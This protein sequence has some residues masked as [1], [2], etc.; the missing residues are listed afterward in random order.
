MDEIRSYQPDRP[1]KVQKEDRFNRWPFAER[2]ADTIG[3]SSDPSGLV[4]GIYGEWGDGKSS[5]LNLMSEALKKYDNVVLVKFN[6]WYFRSEAKL[7]EGFFSILAE[8]L[9]KSLPSK[10]EE[11]GRVLQK[12]GSILS[13]ASGSFLGGMVSVN[14][15]EAIAKIG[16]KMAETDLEELRERVGAILKESNKR[17][18][19]LI[20]DIDR[21]DKEE[22]QAIFKLVKL[23]ASFE[24][25][26]YV[27]AFDD[28]MVAESLSEKYG[29]LNAGRNFLEKIIQVPLRLPAA[30][31]LSLRNL[32]FEGVDSALTSSKVTLTDEQ[33]QI[34][35]NEF[36]PG[37]E[38]RVRTPR[39][40]KRY[41]NVL[42]FA[43]PLLK[44]E[45]NPVDQMLIEGLRVFYPSLYSAIR[46][47]PDVF[48]GNTRIVSEEKLKKRTDETISESLNN[49]GLT[50]GEKEAVT[51]LLEKLFPEISSRAMH[52]SDWKELWVREQRVC[53]ERYF[54]RYFSYG[55]PP[56]DVSDQSIASF[57]VE[58]A[59][60]NIEKIGNDFKGLSKNNKG[61]AHLIEKLRYLE[62]SIQPPIAEKLAVAIAQNGNI[63]PE[64]S[65][66]F[67]FLGSFS[68]GAIFVSMLISRI[69]MTSRG[70][71]AKE[72]IDK[73]N[74]LS[75]AVECFRWLRHGADRPE[76]E[77]KLPIETEKS[78]GEFLAD[79]IKGVAST[80]ALY[81]S[82]PNYA[83]QML[84]I[85]N[86]F[87]AKS[88][89][90]SYL[91]L[92]FSANSEEVSKFLVVLTPTAYGGGKALPFKSD[93][94]RDG[95]NAV[96]NFIDPSV[97]LEYLSKLYGDKLNASKY[98]FGDDIT[99]ENRVAN[100]FAFVHAQVQSETTTAAADVEINKPTL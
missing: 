99:V 38:P 90:E 29:G 66:T 43:L 49:M 56:D 25:V 58:A 76:A 52:G 26:T 4:I 11:L 24:N 33:T 32:T 47:N 41:A 44:G 48:L 68:Q 13:L 51:R 89:V 2:I 20:D 80:E 1:I 50:S 67:S 72:V 5:T 70:N 7:L 57:L 93:F 59:E 63:L 10:A 18:V 45:V 77:R 92:R 30:D 96:R 22:V 75:F 86:E 23:S 64:E 98:H 54:Q 46:E 36:V 84:W 79:K 74:P 97:I 65:T 62:N 87:G 21:L 31:S 27:L 19:V 8:N 55:V 100:Q 91:K 73:A 28:G 88:E 12:I 60:S 16:E 15:G 61:I 69:E 42:A 39:Q 71:L 81:L 34:F 14:P 95:Y 85:W 9:G 40:A 37:I 82:Y 3:Q 6:P 35:V 53:S 83:H 17:I 78:L 94:Q